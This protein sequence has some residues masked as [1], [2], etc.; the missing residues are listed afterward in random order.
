MSHPTTP[1]EAKK[2]EKE[3]EEA[4]KEAKKAEKLRLTK[5]YAD[6]LPEA[7]LEIEG[8]WSTIAA[9][10]T[11]Y[12]I[13]TDPQGVRTALIPP[14]LQAPTAPTP[15]PTYQEAKAGWEAADA[16][17]A[18]AAAAYAASWHPPLTAPKD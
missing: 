6:S 13:V 5:E 2:A 7:E 1:N 12:A 15:L 4:E 10:S 16:A 18:D 14:P 17:G 3:A 8:N 9:T 11:T